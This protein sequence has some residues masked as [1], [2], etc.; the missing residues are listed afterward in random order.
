[1]ELILYPNPILT[2][3]TEPVTEFNETLHKILDEMVPIMD[4]H[5]GI[6]LS[7]NQVGISKS[8]FIMRDLKGK[9]WE[10]INPRIVRTE[11]IQCSLKEGCLSLPGVKAEV[12]RPEQLTIE[13]QDR[14]GYEMKI[15]A[16][17]IEAVC[18]S[19]EID[20]LNGIFFM[21][22]LSRQARRAA[23]REAGKN[24]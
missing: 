5:E 8:F 22:K 15:G 12:P 13:F 2:T 21:E 20:H 11:G 18:I 19:H 17:G 24:E 7:A 10:I 9:L 4:K 16:W 6:G 14:T 23:L 3:Q 1:M